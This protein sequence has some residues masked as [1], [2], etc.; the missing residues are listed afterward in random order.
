MKATKTISFA[1]E[2]PKIHKQTEA[3]LIALFRAKKKK[4]SK[5]FLNYDTLYVENDLYKYYDLPAEDYIV[6]IFLGNH[7]IPFTT[8]RSYSEKKWVYY[9][10]ALR[11]KFVIS[12]D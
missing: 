11:E 10:S 6:L 2:Y 1:H 4:F 12:S 3:I 9:K 8:V 7:N 5:E